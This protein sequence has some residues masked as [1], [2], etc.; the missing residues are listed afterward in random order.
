ML[1]FLFPFPF[2]LIGYPN[3]QNYIFSHPQKWTICIVMFLN[4]SPT[5]RSYIYE[6]R[7]ILIFIVKLLISYPH[8]FI[9]ESIAGSI[10]NVILSVVNLILV[11]RKE[12]ID[13]I[14]NFLLEVFVRLHFL[15]RLIMLPIFLYSF[16]KLMGS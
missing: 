1:F 14:E 4:D 2:L 5:K 8:H 12:S 9:A 10:K 16:T 15:A 3:V 7:S 13:I 11:K 6:F